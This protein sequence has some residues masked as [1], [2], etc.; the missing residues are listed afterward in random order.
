N[1]ARY[2]PRRGLRKPVL[3][4]SRCPNPRKQRMGDT[5]LPAERNWDASLSQPETP[6]GLVMWGEGRT[7]GDAARAWEGGQRQGAEATSARLYF[8]EEKNVAKRGSRGLP[9]WSDTLKGR[10]S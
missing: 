4:E 5:R 3:S 9:R 2:S 6:G 8:Q 1:R 7:Y 10:D